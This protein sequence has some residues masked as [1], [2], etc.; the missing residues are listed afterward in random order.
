MKAPTTQPT[1]ARSRR[2]LLRFMP[3]TQTTTN[4][5][6][7]KACTPPFIAFAVGAGS[8]LR[9]TSHYDLGIPGDIC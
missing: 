4:A 7:E 2:H 5:R 9:A 6:P 1:P 3:P 8:G